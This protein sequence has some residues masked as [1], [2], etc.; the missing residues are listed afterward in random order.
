MSGSAMEALNE[1]E[2]K[3][4]ELIVTS[5]ITSAEPVGSRTLSK[6]LGH[7]W[8]SATIRNVMS[9]LE[10]QG[11]LF[12][13]HVVAGRIPTGKAFRYYVNSLLVYR[14]L[15][16]NELRVMDALFKH[17]YPYTEQ[18]MEDA[19]RVLAN[20]GQ[21]AGIVV[22]P[23]ADTMFF[24]EIEFVKLSGQKVLVLFV[25]SAGIVHSR[26]VITEEN[27]SPQLLQG[28]KQ[29]MNERCEGMP[30]YALKKEI[31]ED[32]RRDKEAFSTLMRKVLDVLDTI[33]EDED[34]RDVYIE[35]TSTI[36][37]VPEFS[38][39][40]RLRELFQAFEKK[41]KLLGLLDRSLEDEE[42]HVM[43]GTETGVQE[44][45]DVSIITSVYRIGSRNRGILGVM[46]PVRMD[47]SRIIPIVNETAKMVTQLLSTM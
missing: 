19:S 36:I 40:K 16:Q 31:Y 3:I 1:R 27:L 30:F 15:G 18:V 14:G 26:L 22:E 8:S 10:E 39:I 29:Y 42:I 9:D 38:D 35:G 34:H 43:I 2:V 41:E 21:Y 33:V 6:L 11:F 7:R 46:G 44:M 13:P 17:Q 24:K 5:Y 32:I 47:Y 45:R 28:M 23:K 12:K 37:G 20:L 4:L 25:T